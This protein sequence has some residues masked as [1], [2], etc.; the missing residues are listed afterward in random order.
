MFVAGIVLFVVGI[1][2][3]LIPF[4]GIP[5]MLAGALL[6]FFGFLK[7]GMRLGLGVG[8]IAAKGAVQA[9]RATATHAT[10]K[11][12]PDCAGRLPN[13]ANVCLRCGYRFAPSPDPA[14]QAPQPGPAWTDPRVAAR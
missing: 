12:C 10:T 14:A 1:P 6:M 3:L 4:I 5:M 11:S 13:A 9:G 2:L 7:G 8:K